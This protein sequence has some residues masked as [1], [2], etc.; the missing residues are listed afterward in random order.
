MRCDLRS[1][2]GNLRVLSFSS[3]NFLHLAALL[4]TT[5]LIDLSCPQRRNTSLKVP[6]SKVPVK[7]K[8]SQIRSVP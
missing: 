2:H 4:W 1:M 3:L 6:G 7:A 8:I 5:L